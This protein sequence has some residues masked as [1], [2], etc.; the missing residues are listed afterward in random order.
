MAAGLKPAP[1][2]TA[3]QMPLLLTMPDCTPGIRDEA[4]V[5]LARAALPRVRQALSKHFLTLYQK[6]RV[7]LMTRDGVRAVV[8]AWVRGLVAS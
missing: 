6:V 2:G 8:V 3:G 5:Q 1:S 4:I 7:L